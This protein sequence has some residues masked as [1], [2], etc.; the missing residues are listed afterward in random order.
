MI[1]DEILKRECE[2]EYIMQQ[3]ER[4]RIRHRHLLAIRKQERQEKA[5]LALLDVVAG[6]FIVI[7][8]MAGSSLDYHS[9]LPIGSLLISMIYLVIY[10]VW[11][12]VFL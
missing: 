5:I 6:V 10:G 1:R 9:W 3:K 4:Q 7:F 2:K 8:I 11:R 12:G